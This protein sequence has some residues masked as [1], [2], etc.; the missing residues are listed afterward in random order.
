MT[1]YS[2][3]I[4]FCII[5]MSMATNANVASTE[6]HHYT[7]CFNDAFTTI[8]ASS[9]PATIN[10]RKRSHTTIAL[11]ESPPESSSRERPPRRRND[12]TSQQPR[13]RQRN[14][15][16]NI[17]PPLDGP[18]GAPQLPVV[19]TKDPAIIARWLEENIGGSDNT[20]GYSVLGYDQESTA[21]PPWKPE[22]AN[23]PDGPA[24]VQLSTPDSCLIVQL[25]ICGD[26][27]AM[28]APEILRQ[29]INNPKIIK[30]G[31]GIDDDALELFRWSKD[32]HKEEEMLWKMRSRFDIGC[33]LPDTKSSRR[34]G[35][36]YSVFVYS[37]YTSLIL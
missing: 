22:R 15:L 6:T 35:R 17:C 26:G 14:G 16:S 32:S 5:T 13:R 29:V 18:V 31:V 37:W 20:N 25:A 27:S 1:Y 10:T 2:T 24:T 7:S 3:L 11:Y 19:T 12:G 28:Y 23:L 8:S 9:L 33:I 36:K 4:L 30:V 21:K 34:A